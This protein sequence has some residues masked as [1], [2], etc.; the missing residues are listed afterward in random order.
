MSDPL[1]FIKQI[2]TNT[3]SLFSSLVTRLIEGLS[4]IISQISFD[5]KNPGPKTNLKTPLEI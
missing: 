3:Q 2:L 1:L 5:E 4:R